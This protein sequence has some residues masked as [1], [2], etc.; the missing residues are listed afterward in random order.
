LGEGGGETVWFDGLTPDQARYASR[1]LYSGCD[2]NVF[3]PRLSAVENLRFHV[4]VRGLSWFDVRPRTIQ[5]LDQ[6]RLSEFA[7]RRVADYSTGM[8]ARLALVA[9]LSVAPDLLLLDEPT[10][11]QDPESRQLI[12]DVL[13]TFV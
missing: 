6:L 2:E 5:F 3:F 13:L 7:E 12:H 4:G 8:R 1:T 11:S 9:A 10:R